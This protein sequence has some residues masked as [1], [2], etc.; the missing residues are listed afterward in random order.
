MNILNLEFYFLAILIVNKQLKYFF[1]MMYK[2]FFSINN[3][4]YDINTNKN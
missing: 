4:K 3:S 2:N 1:S